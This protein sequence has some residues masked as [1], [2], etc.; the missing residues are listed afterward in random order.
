M[1]VTN[2][3]INMKTDS[4]ELEGMYLGLEKLIVSNDLII[5]ILSKHLKF[6]LE[7]GHV[8][9]TWY[10]PNVLSL[11]RFGWFL[12]R[13]KSLKQYII[14]GVLILAMDKKFIFLTLS[15]CMCGSLKRSLKLP[16]L[17]N[18]AH[19]LNEYKEPSNI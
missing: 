12:F 13:N 7:R 15:A 16:L 3:S 17:A 1:I 18:L 19:A 14:N 4:M 8:L 6:A 11:T 9:S 5:Q 10:L 2:D